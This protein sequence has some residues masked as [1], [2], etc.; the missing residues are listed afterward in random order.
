MNKISGF[1]YTD[2]KDKVVTG[3]M[4][5]ADNKK[6]YIECISKFHALSLK[7]T[8]FVSMVILIV[9]TNHNAH[10]GCGRTN[11]TAFSKTNKQT[12]K[13]LKSCMFVIVALSLRKQMIP[14]KS[15]HPLEQTTSHSSLNWPPGSTARYYR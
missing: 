2:K 3:F 4:G 13:N 7:G 10:H 14:R 1:D 8:S 5:F 12:N 11:V 6:I 15:L 9:T